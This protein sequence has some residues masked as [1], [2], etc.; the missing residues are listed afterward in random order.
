MRAGIV[1]DLLQV[2]AVSLELSVVRVA[3]VASSRIFWVLPAR[4]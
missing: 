4:D 1:E 2:R 3:S